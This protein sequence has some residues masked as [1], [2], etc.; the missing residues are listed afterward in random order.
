[1]PFHTFG[2]EL[3][4][5]NCPKKKSDTKFKSAS[6]LAT[7]V[8]ITQ[9]IVFL[10]FWVVYGILMLTNVVIYSVL[11]PILVLI[12]LANALQAPELL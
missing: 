2:P 7:W 3:Y 10:S 8:L 11:N 4:G 6:P 9:L 12:L 5:S 1:M